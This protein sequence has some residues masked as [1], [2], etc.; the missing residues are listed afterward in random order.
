MKKTLIITTIYLLIGMLAFSLADPVNLVLNTT[1][2]PV[3]ALTVNGVG[4]PGSTST[5][6]IEETD[7]GSA[8]S[9][10]FTYIGNQPVNLKVTSTNASTYNTSFR[11]IVSGT[12]AQYIPYSLTIDYDGA[13]AGTQTAVT[14]GIG[15]AL[16]HTGG[17]YNLDST[18]IVTLTSGT[19]AAGTYSD[20]LTFEIVAQ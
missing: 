2:A 1:I 18:L 6:I 10:P 5:K 4:G 15:A 9:I 20:T 7:L 17:I 3:S 19:Y 11:L 13:G 14:S 12:P 16:V 8:I